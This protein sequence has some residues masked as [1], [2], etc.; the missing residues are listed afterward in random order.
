MPKLFIAANSVKETA[1]HLQ[2]V[3]DDGTG[4]LKE[5]EVQAPEYAGLSGANWLMD[6]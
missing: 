4:L 3:Y 2:I 5:S 1:G 6:Q